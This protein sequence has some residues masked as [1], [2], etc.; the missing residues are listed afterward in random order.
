MIPLS[1]VFTGDASTNA[2]IR[3]SSQV[4]TN[5]TQIC[6]RISASTRNRRIVV[7]ALVLALML[8][9]V[10]MLVSG[11]FHREITSLVFV[12]ALVKT[13]LNVL[14][15]VGALITLIDFTLS[16]ARRFYSSMGN[17]SAEKRLR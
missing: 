4:E 2:S 5:I 1:P 14:T 17:P 3:N 6:A 7:L 10:L 15:A 16:N 8:A 13:R 12:S 9:L 11:R